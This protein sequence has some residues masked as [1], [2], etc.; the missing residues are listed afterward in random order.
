MRQRFALVETPFGWLGILGGEAGLQRVTLPRH[1]RASAGQDILQ[2]APDAIEDMAAFAGL[3][4]RLSRYFAGEA[5]EFPDPLDLTRATPF[6]QAVY[7]ELR[8]IPYGATAT[9]SQIARRLG[10][11]LASRAVGRVN[12]TNPWP[13]IV[14]CHRLTGTDGSLRGYA[15]GLP[16]KQALLDLE[17]GMM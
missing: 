5:V 15:G 8:A 2:R 11:P 7:A 14:P 16:M 17:R 3:M 12:A 6:Q 9:Y 4:D 10:R 1:S 13:V